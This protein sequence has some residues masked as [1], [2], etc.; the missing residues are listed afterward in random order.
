LRAL[1]VRLGLLSAA[2][3]TPSWPASP[4]PP[5]AAAVPVAGRQGAGRA[6][7]DVPPIATSATPRVRRP[8]PDRP[9]LTWR[10]L[11]LALLSERTLH[12]LL[13]VGALLILVSASVIS[14]LNPTRLAPMPHLGAL[15]ATTSVFAAA[16]VSLRRRLGLPRTGSALLAIAAAFLPLDIWALGTPE[17]LRWTPA[18]TWLAASPLCLLAYLAVCRR[19]KGSP[20]R[21]C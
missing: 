2:R 1:H 17:L 15:V 19:E 11:G 10:H 4:V 16:G 20:S 18:T 8:R 3:P 14:T 7:P 12:T 21:W 9:P 5:L 13:L 6:P